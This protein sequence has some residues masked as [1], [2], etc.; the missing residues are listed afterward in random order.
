MTCKELAILPLKKQV[1][2]KYIQD[3]GNSLE[4]FWSVFYIFITDQNID[5]VFFINKN[6]IL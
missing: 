5:I 2:L 4:G 3:G 6:K 1:Y